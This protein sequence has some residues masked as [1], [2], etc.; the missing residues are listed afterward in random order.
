MANC[1]AHG[2]TRK[3]GSIYLGAHRPDGTPFEAFFTL[4]KCGCSVGFA[5][6]TRLSGTP[7]TEWVPT[8]VRA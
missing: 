7:I 2:K 8:E 3:T 5:A 6:G 1:P 4:H